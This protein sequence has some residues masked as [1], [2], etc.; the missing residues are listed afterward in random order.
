MDLLNT[1]DAVTTPTNSLRPRFVRLGARD[2][3]TLS[4]HSLDFEQVDYTRP[5]LKPQ[6]PCFRFGYIGQFS[7]SKALIWPLRHFKNSPRNTV[8]YRGDLGAIAAEYEFRARVRGY[9][10]WSDQCQGYAAG[11]SRVIS[12]GYGR[13]GCVDRSLAVA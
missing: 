8:R 12:H 5:S 1:A 9:D 4:R 11:M 6:V 13:Y 2:R 7:T 10:P 3:F